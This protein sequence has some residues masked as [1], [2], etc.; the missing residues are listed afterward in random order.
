M[1]AYLELLDLR[2][3][4]T[5]LGN[6]SRRGRD[7]SAPSLGSIIGVTLPPL[8]LS[9][10]LSTGQMVVTIVSPNNNLDSL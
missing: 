9:V 8:F 4:G 10:P 1:M 6:C 2:H 7:V 5:N 3:C